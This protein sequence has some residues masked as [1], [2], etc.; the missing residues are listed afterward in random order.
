MILL[1]KE[2]LKGQGHLGHGR[3]AQVA[4]HPLALPVQTAAD[5]AVQNELLVG[6]AGEKGP[7]QPVAE[8]GGALL[9]QGVV[10][11]QGVGLMGLH[12]PLRPQGGAGIGKG[13]EGG[14]GLFVD[15]AFK[16]TGEKAHKFSVIAV[17][18]LFQE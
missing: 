3:V 9:P 16:H 17:T 14:G 13:E 2:L 18:D 12:L 15:V 10:D 4:D 8:Q 6:K 5:K 11:P 1:G 7:L